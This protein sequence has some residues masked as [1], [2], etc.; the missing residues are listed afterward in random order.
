MPSNQ[1]GQ[2]VSN[3]PG[4]EPERKKT[5]KTRL[6]ERFPRD[7]EDVRDREDS[8]VGRSPANFPMN[9]S[10]VGAVAVGTDTSTV[11]AIDPCQLRRLWGNSEW[12][13]LMTE[14]DPA[15]MAKRVEELLREHGAAIFHTGYDGACE[16]DMPGATDAQS[17]LPPYG[18]PA[19]HQ[20][21]GV[22][23]DAPR[24]GPMGI[25]SAT[26]EE[27]AWQQTA[28]Q[29]ARNEDFYRSL[30][31]QVATHLGPEVYV[32]DDGSVQDSP[33]RLKI[34]PLVSELALRVRSSSFQIL[35]RARD[36]ANL[37]PLPAKC[38]SS[39][40]CHNPATRE[41]F[42][43][44]GRALFY[45]C[46]RC[47]QKWLK[48][49]DPNFGPGGSPDII[50]DHRLDS[51]GFVPQYYGL[52]L[53]DSL[54]FGWGPFYR[55]FVEEHPPVDVKLP[56]MSVDGE[57]AKKFDVLERRMRHWL[58]SNGGKVV[59]PKTN[60]KVI[61]HNLPEEV[62]RNVR[63]NWVQAQDEFKQID[64]HDYLAKLV[65]ETGR[66]NTQQ[67]GADPERMLRP[68]ELVASAKDGSERAFVIVVLPNKGILLLR[69]HKGYW[70]LPGGNVDPSDA[71]PMA[72]AIREL[73]EE[74]ALRV[75]RSQ[76]KKLSQQKTRWYFSVVLTPAQAR[77]IK[78]SREHTKYKFEPDISKASRKIK[79]HSGGGPGKELARLNMRDKLPP[80]AE[81]TPAEAPKTDKSSKKKRKAAADQIPGGKA[82]KKDPSDFDQ[83]EL[84]KGIKVE[85]EHTDDPKL[86]RE[87]AM[88]HLT[89]FADYY[90]RLDKMETEAKKEERTGAA[91]KVRVQTTRSGERLVA[92]GY[93]EPNAV[94]V[95]TFRRSEAEVQRHLRES[96]KEEQKYIRDLTLD[97]RESKPD[98]LLDSTTVN[99][100][101]YYRVEIASHKALLSEV[102][103]RLSGNGS[104]AGALGVQPSRTGWVVQAHSGQLLSLPPSAVGPSLERLLTL[105]RNSR[106][107]VPLSMILRH[108]ATTQHSTPPPTQREV[109]RGVVLASAEVEATFVAERCSIGG[110]IRYDWT[111]DHPEARRL[112]KWLRETLNSDD[113]KVTA[114]RAAWAAGEQDQLP[115]ILVY[116]TGRVYDGWARLAVALENQVQALPAYV[117]QW[118]T[119]RDAAVSS[120][121]LAEHHKLFDT[122]RETLDKLIEEETAY[123][124]HLLKLSEEPPPNEIAQLHHLKHDIIWNA[125]AV[126]LHHLY[127]EA[128][129]PKGSSLQDSAPSLSAAV[130]ESGW[131]SEDHLK[132]ELTAAAL[133]CRGGWVVLNWCA[134]AGKVV[135]GTYDQHDQGVNARAVPF[136][137]IDMW[138]HAYFGDYGTDK[139]G[140]IQWYL[141]HVD[142][143]KPEA[144]LMRLR[145]LRSLTAGAEHPQHNEVMQLDDAKVGPDP[146]KQTF[147]AN[148]PNRKGLRALLLERSQNPTGL[149]ED[150]IPPPVAEQPFR[151]GDELTASARIAKGNPAKIKK[152]KSISPGL[153]GKSSSTTKSKKSS[154][155]GY[156]DEFAKLIERKR[157]V[158]NKTKNR[159]KFSSLPSQQQSKIYEEW[160]S[161]HH[162]TLHPSADTAGPSAEDTEGAKDTT[163]SKRVKSTPP[164]A[165]KENLKPH[166][167]EAFKSVGDAAKFTEDEKKEVG[168]AVAQLPAEEV[169]KAAH[170]FHVDTNDHG[171]PHA[172]LLFLRRLG[173]KGLDATIKF[174]GRLE[175][176]GHDTGDRAKILRRQLGDEEAAGMGSKAETKK[177]ALRKN[178][179]RAF[180]LSGDPQWHESLDEFNKRSKSELARNKKRKQRQKLSDTEGADEPRAASLRERVVHYALFDAVHPEADPDEHGEDTRIVGKRKS[181]KRKRRSDKHKD[182]DGLGSRW[183]KG[184][185]GGKTTSKV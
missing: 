30:L 135:L 46:E 52:P 2:S 101:D 22:P 174:T 19:F 136:F 115:P 153:K 75:K 93:F 164:R 60:R 166:A 35:A 6:N 68:E 36:S 180:D 44:D 65:A 38:N 182:V 80:L 76:V 161:A 178:K 40:S 175:R 94:E 23:E 70:Q 29:H 41:V 24:I 137:A 74:T 20:K 134:D 18:T 57:L 185:R 97:L 3:P 37:K 160:K 73:L 169:N 10:W 1:P 61:Y 147:E 28:A 71:D 34:P 111:Q 156:P 83:S 124:A 159:V 139:A 162:G 117:V 84:D 62:R 179:G 177:K 120:G 72:A 77:K 114:V 90:T 17:F 96:V 59:N 168:E 4:F 56:L 100:Q 85:R 157:Y 133:G 92:D 155:M 113:P 106:V 108:A 91:V 89:E 138:E 116:Q 5:L 87:I 165:T 112:K 163:T 130:R 15:Y 9:A 176:M 158:S 11:V 119:K 8:G 109:A 58:W 150:K 154:D 131:Q 32:S 54:Y 146:A 127:F 152:T 66:T 88:D 98:D 102:K 33:L 143:R 105:S 26:P 39:Y 14:P 48:D 140:Y 21:P 128:L 122:Y 173:L 63:D 132:R 99:A 95:V 103:R 25:P 81:D 79:K 107:P 86:A 27:D 123:R 118:P 12:A 69:S 55:E 64:W 151:T 13:D 142:W 129:S 51:E 31:D 145:G 172:S 183:V 126:V 121:T 82:D 43:A 171:A 181:K 49:T 45:P 104:G 141:D 78:L 67:Q 148:D 50:S 184:D 144:E 170:E 53:E 125:N 47:Y 167:L 16:I 7:T 42:W 110:L 149:T